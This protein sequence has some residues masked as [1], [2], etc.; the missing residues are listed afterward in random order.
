MPSEFHDREPLLPF[1]NPKSRPWY[2]YGYFLE[3]LIQQ[4]DDDDDDDPDERFVVFY[5]SFVLIERRIL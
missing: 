3:L 4:V 1:R 2:R 5:I